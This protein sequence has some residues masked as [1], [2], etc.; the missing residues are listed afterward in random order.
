MQEM[1]ENF[2]SDPQSVATIEKVLNV[3][4]ILT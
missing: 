2:V 3:I 4:L 1:Y